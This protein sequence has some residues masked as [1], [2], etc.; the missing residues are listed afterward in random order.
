[1]SFA[2][3][4]YQQARVTTASPVAILVSL[5]EGAI[6]ALRDAQVHHARGEIAK[7]GEALSK[8]HAIVSELELT[9][10]RER[11][12]EMCDELTRLYDFVLR[13]IGDA[14]ASADPSRVNPG[15]DVLVRLHSAWS[16]IARRGT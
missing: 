5:Y 8:A 13:G 10:D 9:L 12:P 2:A 6:R 15:I 11:A 16:E 14:T 7:R 1:M 4:Q 3:L